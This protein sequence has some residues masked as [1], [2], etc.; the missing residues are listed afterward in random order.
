[1]DRELE[2]LEDLIRYLGRSIKHSREDCVPVEGCWF[3]TPRRFV[4]EGLCIV[5]VAF[6]LGFWALRKWRTEAAAAKDQETKPFTI[7]LRIAIV[8]HYALSFWYKA[9]RPG[10]QF[11]ML[12]PC[13][14]SSLFW[15]GVALAPTGLLRAQAAHHALTLWAAVMI[16]FLTPDTAGLTE[17]FEVEF[18]WFQHVFL[19][20]LPV[21]AIASGRVVPSDYGWTIMVATTAFLFA[22]YF[23]P[24]TVLGLCFNANINYMLHPPKQFLAFGA[25][26]RLAAI[27]FFS[28]MFTLSRLMALGVEAACGHVRSNAKAKVS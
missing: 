24:G 21:H 7:W 28:A 22:F 12:M 14:V 10:G 23:G 9:Q 3:I 19:S 8:A 4:V 5:P 25:Q 2:R 6:V 26:F 13:H 18:F 16:V 15:V 1:M 17:L 11:F 20:I 27:P